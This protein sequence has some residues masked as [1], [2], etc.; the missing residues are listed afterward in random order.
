LAAVTLVKAKTA[1]RADVCAAFRVSDNT[2][3]RWIRSFGDDG[4]L[5]LVPDQRGPKGPFKLTESLA[6]RIRAPG[7]EGSSLASV[8]EETGVS[9]DTVRR[10]LSG[11]PSVRPATPAGD[12]LILLA[13]PVPREGERALARM[14]LLTGAEPVIT[15]GASQPIAGARVVLPALWVTRLLDAFGSVYVSGRAAFYSLRSLVLAL[16]F[17]AL[18]GEPRA[19]GLT[20]ISPVDLGRLIGLDRA[21][22]VG[23][24]RR[25]MDV[26]AGL[27]RSGRLLAELARRHAA[28]HLVTMERPARYAYHVGCPRVVGRAT[29]GRSQPCP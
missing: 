6:V 18:V 23:T 20:R 16:V 5:G 21:P 4:V 22:E 2:L 1:T 13:P 27:R 3:R 19:E 7:S 11:E 12:D 25:R 8:A 14:G 29:Y 9:I 26:L 24:V 28:T 15:E 17:S 10:E